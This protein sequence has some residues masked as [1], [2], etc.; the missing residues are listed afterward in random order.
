MEPD[1]VC[2]EGF[3]AATVRSSELGPVANADP[4]ACIM[5]RESNRVLTASSTRIIWPS[6]APAGTFTVTLRPPGMVKVRLVPVT[7][8]DLLIASVARSSLNIIG[9]Q[10]LRAKAV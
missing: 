3:E 10:L 1:G 7:A 9:Y 5:L 8:S 6:Y 2:K 4:S